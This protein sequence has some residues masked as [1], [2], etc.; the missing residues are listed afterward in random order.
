MIRFMGEQYIIGNRFQPNAY[1]SPFCVIRNHRKRVS[2]RGE[3][4]ALIVLIEKK[5]LIY[6][7]WVCGVLDVWVIAPYIANTE[8]FT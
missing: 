7:K 6:L 8:S 5:Y 4:D 1:R 3:S 2:K